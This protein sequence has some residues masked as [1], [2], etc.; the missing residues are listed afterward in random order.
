MQLVQMRVERAGRVMREQCRS[1][2]AGR[3]VIL[4][5]AGPNA[6]RG[7]RLELPQRTALA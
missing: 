4:C 7:K 5:A 2:V 3:P 1:K 6:A